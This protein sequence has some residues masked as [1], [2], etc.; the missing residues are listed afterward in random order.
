MRGRLSGW[1]SFDKLFACIKRCER[2]FDIFWYQCHHGG[3]KEL[4]GEI[5]LREKPAKKCKLRRLRLRGL[6]WNQMSISCF[7]FENDQH[8]KF[9][10]MG[11]FENKIPSHMDATHAISKSERKFQNRIP[12]ELDQKFDSAGISLIHWIR[13]NNRIFKIRRNKKRYGD[14]YSR[15][16]T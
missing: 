10:I 2:K 11:G 13:Y 7:I 6:T 4:Q 8:K 15:N 3:K 12:K 16:P 1:T 14:S 5:V 9:N